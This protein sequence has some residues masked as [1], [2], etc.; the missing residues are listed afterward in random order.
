MEKKTE[1][2]QQIL[3]ENHYTFIIHQNQD[4]PFILLYFPFQIIYMVCLSETQ[5][6]SYNGQKSLINYFNLILMH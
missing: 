5:I 2:L 1:T 4:F 6:L 3:S